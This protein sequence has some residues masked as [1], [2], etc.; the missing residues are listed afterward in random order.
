MTAFVEP[1]PT[2]TAALPR[3]RVRRQVTPTLAIG[4]VIMALILLYAIIGPMMVPARDANVGAFKARLKPSAEHI[5]GTDTQGRDIFATLTYATPSSLKIGLLAGLVGLTIGVLLGLLAGFFPG[6]IDTVIRTATDVLTTIPGIA[7]LVVIATMMRTMTV[8]IMALIIASLAW[9]Y[10]TRAIRSQTLSLRE[11]AYVQIARLNGLSGLEIVIKEVLPNLLPYIAAS[12]VATVSQSM[13]SAIGLEALGLGPQNVPTLGMMIYWAQFYT[14]ILR[15]FWWWWA[16]PIVM[17]V[18]IFV[19][20][21]FI[22]A[23]LDQLVNTK[24]RRAE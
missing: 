14:A 9:R 6:P 17:I 3:R 10:P 20:L 13:L 23:G 19:G 8:E 1:S 7:L 18:L 4:L 15:G 22:S 12:F 5:L 11:R 16:P 2:M 24:L 21:L